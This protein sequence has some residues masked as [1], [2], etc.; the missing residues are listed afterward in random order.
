MDFLGHKA[1]PQSVRPLETKVSAIR[2]F[3]EHKTVKDLCKF[4]G[5]INFYR[6]FTTKAGGILRPL[7]PLLT[8]EKGTKRPLK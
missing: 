3:P 1:H 8:P 5:P 6:R 7:D 4:L 2:D